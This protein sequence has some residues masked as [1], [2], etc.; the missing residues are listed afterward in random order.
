MTPLAIWENYR[1]FTSNK[2]NMFALGIIII[3]L[4][5]AILGKLEKNK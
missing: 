4:L 1:I 3:V 2:K 5:L